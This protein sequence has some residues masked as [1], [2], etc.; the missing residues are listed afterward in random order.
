MRSPEPASSDRGTA[1][2]LAAEAE[3]TARADPDGAAVL[4]TEALARAED[5]QPRVVAL[6]AIGVARRSQGDWSAARAALEQAI[7]EASEAGLHRDAALA[8]VTLSSIH[9]LGGDHAGA[10][11]ELTTAM[12]DL[13]GTDLVAAIVQLGA[14]RIAGG[15][16]QGGLDAFDSVADRIDELTADRRAVFHL[17][18]GTA[19]IGMHRPDAA[20]PAFE[21]A[22]ALRR[23][24]GEP[25]GRL[26]SGPLHHLARAHA[27]SG[28][29]PEALACFREIDALGLGAEDVPG[30]VDRASVLLAAGLVAEAEASA[31]AARAA[32]AGADAYWAPLAPL[33]HAEILE[34]M[35][36]ARGAAA[37]AIEAARAFEIHGDRNR[38]DRGRAIAIRARQDA[39]SLDA[40]EVAE[41]SRRL[42]AAGAR[43]DA[44][45]TRMHLARV[46]PPS[47]AVRRELRHVAELPPV[48][49]EDASLVAEASAR[50]ALI[51]EDFATMSRALEDGLDALAAWRSAIGSSELRASTARLAAPL[52][53]LAIAE[54]LRAGSAVDV[55]RASERLRTAAIVSGPPSPHDPE[56]NRLLASLRSAVAAGSESD[57]DRAAIEAEIRAH[58]RISQRST[59]R[60]RSFDLDRVVEGLDESVLVEFVE[61]GGVVTGVVVAD[62]A[63][64]LHRLG[65]SDRV[66]AERDSLRFSMERLSSPHGT[67]ASRRA[68]QTVLDASAGHLA[69]MLFAPLGID[70]ERP[71]VIVPSSTVAAVPW[72]ALPSLRGRAFSVSP[73]AAL[74]SDL[75]ET[76]RGQGRVAVGVHDPPSAVSEATA[77]AEL[78]GCRVI[79]GRDAA[80][81]E[82]LAAIEGVDVAHLAC[83]GRYRT[84]NPLMSSMQMS[85]GPMTVYDIERLARTPS[86]IVLS[87]CEVGRTARTP[88]EGLMG[89]TASLMAAGTRTVVAASTVVADEA[90][91]SVMV[92]FHRALQGGAEPPAALAEARIR[93]APEPGRRLA[94]LSFV[95]LGV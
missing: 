86:T 20:I 58:A 73:S 95:S 27:L 44:A 9:A 50:L 8:R 92:D 34:A 46:S 35:G 26:A 39:D 81:A 1:G 21:S 6:R 67:D 55:L 90:T 5:P 18:R 11:I 16:F 45:R 79:T 80:V 28:S 43:L 24:R 33:V 85:D 87:A 47:D 12:D 76:G 63:I 74:R 4:A 25:P 93:S 75:A 17:N 51:D 23:R 54:A 60:A 78:L 31:R 59:S 38:A 30:L 83:H 53:D 94:A 91:R 2:A 37:A 77:V 64:R 3:R 15:D 7:S 48:G 68:F 32:A 42:D 22:L 13:A 88:G 61:H 36:D 62:R 72:S 14:I 71:L 41:L 52:A 65:P 66:A 69:E 56:M 89:M 57:A 82:V 29:T 49:V 19:L 70:P 10:I 84:D 40:G